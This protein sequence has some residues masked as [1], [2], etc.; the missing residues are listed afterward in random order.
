MALAPLASTPL[1]GFQWG[2]GEWIIILI[3]V[4]V[5]FGGTKLPALGKGLGEGIRNFKKG[6]KS[7][8]EKGS[9]GKDLDKEK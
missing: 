2:I 1:V 8:E 5:L 6:L 7:D 3:V 9:T 4:V